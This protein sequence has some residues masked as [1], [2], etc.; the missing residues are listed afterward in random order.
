MVACRQAIVTRG[1]DGLDFT[2]TAFGEFV[3][4]IASN[5]NWTKEWWSSTGYLVGLDFSLTYLLSVVFHSTS[6]E[7]CGQ[8]NLH[9][10]T[11][12]I[13]RSQVQ[14][15]AIRSEPHSEENWTACSEAK[16]FKS[17]S[18][19]LCRRFS[20]LQAACVTATVDSVLRTAFFLQMPLSM[21]MA[22][23]LAIF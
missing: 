21:I 15:N 13:I 6:H 5:D 19:F 3:V 20:L 1:W 16:I 8:C 4:V 12:Y 18:S 7:D 14:C 22:R 10:H 2:R 9:Q 11:S 23:K 17:A